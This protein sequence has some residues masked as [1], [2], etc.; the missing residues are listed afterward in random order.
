MQGNPLG[1]D[2]GT[3]PNLVFTEEKKFDIQQVASQQ[4][5]R[6]W[7]SS[8]STEGRIVTRRQNPQSWFGRPSHSPGGFLCFLCPLESNWTPSATSPT[9]WR[10]ASFPG[11]PRSTSKELPGRCNRTLRSLTLLRSP[12]PGFRGKSPH[13]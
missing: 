11:W 4:N 9:F 12:S 8:S 1:E 10:I 7:A 3:L 6:V 2:R 13:S 5:D